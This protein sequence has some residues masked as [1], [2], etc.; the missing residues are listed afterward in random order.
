M[1]HELEQPVLLE[2][3]AVLLELRKPVQGQRV[4]Q[5]PVQLVQRKPVRGLPALETRPLE[6]ERPERQVLKPVLQEV[7]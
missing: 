4:P 3:G 5:V 2:L 1:K 7:G 6:P